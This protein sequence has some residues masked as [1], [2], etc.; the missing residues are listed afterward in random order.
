[1]WPHWKRELPDR[2]QRIKSLYCPRIHCTER[3]NTYGRECQEEQGLALP[4]RGP[5]RSG[6]FVAMQVW[7]HD[8]N[9]S[10]YCLL[11]NS[12]F[13]CWRKQILA[14]QYTQTLHIS[15]PMISKVG[16]M[17]YRRFY[18][19]LYSPG[20]ISSSSFWRRTTCCYLLLLFRMV[21]LL[22][23]GP[24]IM[25]MVWKPREEISSK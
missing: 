10:S 6:Y 20:G 5:C 17:L 18:K 21:C 4:L 22:G 23:S 15:V 14:A 7:G 12:S 8:T 1:M 11:I 25:R 19:M 24:L 2:K 13:H 9:H 3:A 16:M